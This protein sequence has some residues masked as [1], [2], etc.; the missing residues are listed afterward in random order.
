M[1]TTFLQ[2][3]KPEGQTSS[4]GN[5]STNPFSVFQF[6]SKL[7]TSQV[8]VEILDQQENEGVGK[9]I[10]CW[11]ELSTLPSVESQRITEE[12]VSTSIVVTGVHLVCVPGGVVDGCGPVFMVAPTNVECNIS[13]HSPQ[14]I[15]DRYVLA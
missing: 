13:S 8:V 4:N 3:L 5:H 10:L 2:F 11:E 7:S 9:F 12:E 6:L 1:S 14:S 15:Y